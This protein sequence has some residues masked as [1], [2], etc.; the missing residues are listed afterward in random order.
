MKRT[1]HS[2]LLCALLLALPCATYAQPESLHPDVS[3]RQFKL[4]GAQSI[5]IAYNPADGLL[6]YLQL[7]GQIF[8]L[9]PITAERQQVASSVDHGITVA[10]GFA[11]ATDGTFFVVGNPTR[12]GNNIGVIVRGELNGDQRVWSSVAETEPYAISTGRDHKFNAIEVSPDG[13]YLLVNSGSRTDH[14]EAQ[15]DGREH[16]I[17]SAIFRLPID[18]RDLFLPNDEEGL[19][20]YL[21]ADGVRNSFDMAFAP[22]GDLFAAEN[23]DTRDNPEELNWIRPGHH[24][25]FPWR[26]GTEDTPQQFADFD[27]PDSDMLL[28]PGINMEGTFH[29]DPDYPPP[30][31]GVV[32]T[33]PVLNVGPDAD[34]FRDSADGLI[35]DASDE[36]VK[37]GTFTPHSSPLGLVF[38]VDMKL[39]AEFTGDGFCLSQNDSTLRKYAPFLDPGEDLLHLEL[40]KIADEERYEVRTKRLVRGFTSPVDAV[41]L[42]HKIFVI[43]WDGSG[44]I[45]EITLPLRTATAVSAAP[46]LPSS[47]ALAPN[48]PNPF[49]T[50]TTISYTLPHDGHVRLAIYDASGQKVEQLL[51]QRHVGG[52]YHISWNG[53]DREQRRVASGLYFSILEFDGQRQIRKMLLL[54]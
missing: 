4:V 14:G 32:F 3:I 6:Y 34:H 45:W 17:T 12:G 52:S 13:Q 36:G 38:D 26:I 2:L 33:D 43:E 7:P 30:P 46:P 9:D 42:D 25:G 24:Y 41:L 48:Y 20:D 1:T 49:N 10:V 5:R 11:I 47:F 8:A 31:V 35:K 54:K 39:G 53:T 29:N 37:L 27:P 44:K 23:S 18:T 16:P 28:V 15:N 19:R 22:N 40:T 50:S 21:Y 51:D